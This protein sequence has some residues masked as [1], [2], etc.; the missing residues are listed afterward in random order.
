MAFDLKNYETVKARKK[1]FYDDHPDGRIVVE[2]AGDSPLTYA[3]FKCS[4]YLNP[5]DQ[6]NGLPR[7]TGWALEI[8]DTEIS[9][10][11]S[12]KEY[13]SVNYS[14]WLE[15][16]EES[17]VGRALDNAGYA[18]NMRCSKEEMLKSQNRTSPKFK[19]GEDWQKW[20]Q[21]LPEEVKQ[22][23]KTMS[24]TNKEI[25]NLALANDFDYE[26]IKEAVNNYGIENGEEQ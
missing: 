4:I 9:K 12:G 25:H 2:H 18:S 3:L 23:C 8:R 13:E 14:S 7:S 17:S 6:E 26:K 16:C 15:N 10:S 22:F 1:R 24:L 5:F 20:L 21:G 11:S 19:T